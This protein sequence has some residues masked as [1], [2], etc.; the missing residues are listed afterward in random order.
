[1]DLSG[2]PQVRYC[3]RC[4][5]LLLDVAQMKHYPERVSDDEI[6]VRNAEDVLGKPTKI[7]SRELLIM[8]MRGWIIKPGSAKKLEKGKAWWKSVTPF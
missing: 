7:G 2:A 1:M 5:Q 6:S 8:F 4:A 3:W